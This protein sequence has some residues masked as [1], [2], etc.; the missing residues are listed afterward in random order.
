MSLDCPGGLEVALGF[1]P[2]LGGP[3]VGLVD[4]PVAFFGMADVQLVVAARHCAE[5]SFL[6]PL[7]YTWLSSILA[8]VR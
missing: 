1:C 7:R 5:L 8:E 3:V 2:G 6:V 4:P